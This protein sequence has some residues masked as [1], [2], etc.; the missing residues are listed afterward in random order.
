MGAILCFFFVVFVP[1]I[2][3]ELFSLRPSLAH[4]WGPSS[5]ASSSSSSSSLLIQAKVV[6]KA[7]VPISAASS[8]AHN[9]FAR[10]KV[11]NKKVLVAQVLV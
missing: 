5:S 8:Q 4:E 9:E 11:A 1:C 3:V 7:F 2:P 6:H 10:F